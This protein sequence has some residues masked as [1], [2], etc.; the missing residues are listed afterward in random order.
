MSQVLNDRE[1]IG[2][3]MVGCAALSAVVSLALCYINGTE[4][5][6]SFINGTKQDWFKKNKDHLI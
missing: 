5:T 2:F 4:R 3:A 1:V 6:L